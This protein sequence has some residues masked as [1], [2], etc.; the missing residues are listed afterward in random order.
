MVDKDQLDHPGWGSGIISLSLNRSGDG[1]Y[2][3]EHQKE[4]HCHTHLPDVTVKIGLYHDFPPLV[5]PLSGGNY[6]MCYDE[7]P[8]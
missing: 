1:E 7:H 3:P 2:D 5:I 8:E 6:P 4:R